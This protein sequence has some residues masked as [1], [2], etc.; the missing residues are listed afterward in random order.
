MGPW[1]YGVSK[2]TKSK[3]LKPEGGNGSGRGAIDELG[4]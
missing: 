1:V 2:F 3:G 4:G